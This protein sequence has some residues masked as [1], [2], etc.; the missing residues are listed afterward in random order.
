[1]RKRIIDSNQNMSTDSGAWL[2]LENL[3]QVEVTSEDAAYPIEAALIPR[4]GSGWRAAEPGPQTL[5]VLFDQPQKIRRIRLAFQENRQQ[6]TQEFTVRWSSDGGK[7]Y[8]QIV[9]QQ[10]NF[11]P[12]DTTYE[13]EDYAVDL[14]AMSVLE[15]NIV[16]DISGRHAQAS[17]AEL[18]LA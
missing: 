15:V 12:P 10:Y 17:V 8:R 13:L 7:S 11:S 16:P 9:R 2:D 5:R 6:R 14:A 18:R 4:T 3:A 1:M